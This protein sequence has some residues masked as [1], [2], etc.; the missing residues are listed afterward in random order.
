[1]VPGRGGKGG[2]DPEGRMDT[3]MEA[4]ADAASALL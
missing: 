4:C 3:W 2:V 1:M